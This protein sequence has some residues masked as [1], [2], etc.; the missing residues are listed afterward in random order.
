M[1]G[2]AQ[3][4]PMFALVLLAGETADRYDR[5][6][7]LLGCCALQVVCS[8]GLALLATTSRP[9]LV[10]IFALSAVFGI[11][12]AFTMPTSAALGPM[13]VPREILPRAIGWNTLAMQSGMVLGPWIGG[14]M[15]ASSVPLSYAASAALYVIAGIAVFRI[16][17]NTKPD[18]KGGERLKLIA[19][20]LSPTCGRTRSCSVPSRSISS[21]CCSAA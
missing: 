3:F 18:H 4:V 17:A 12:R 5:R 15:C 13:L 14:L 10:A 6:K 16:G 1:I 19:E 11:G 8:S 2:L 7:I 9:S 21:P 20:G